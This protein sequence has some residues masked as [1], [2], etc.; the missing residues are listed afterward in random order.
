[1]L[2]SNRLKTN[3]LKEKSSEKCSQRRRLAELEG[4]PRREN[5]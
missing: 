5:T 2:I 3:L 1:M 4:I